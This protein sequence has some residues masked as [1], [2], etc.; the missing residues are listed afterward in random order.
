MDSLFAFCE[1]RLN[2]Y[3]FQISKYS[4]STWQVERAYVSDVIFS[5]VV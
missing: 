4:I 3:F 5:N 1:N 2:K